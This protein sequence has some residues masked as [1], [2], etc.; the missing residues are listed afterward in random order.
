[1]NTIIDEKELL[2]VLERN[3][4]AADTYAN[5]EVG[6][7]RDKGHRYYYGEPMGNEV[8]GRSHHVSMD[9]FDAV[10]AVKSMMLETFSADRNICRFDAQGP[11]DDA[12]AKA[13]TIFEEVPSSRC[14]IASCDMHVR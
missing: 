3:I 13:A 12:A 6:A 5:S 14:F 10:E 11:E 7:Q 2:S 8:R 9:V 1:M 4:D